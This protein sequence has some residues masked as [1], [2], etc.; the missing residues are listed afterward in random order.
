MK[1][2]LFALSVFAVACGTAEKEEE[3]TA[4]TEPSS[5]PASAPTSSPTSEPEGGEILLY[6]TSQWSGEWTVADDALTG[7]EGL[8]SS[9]FQETTGVRD[10]DYV[11]NLAGTASTD[12]E[13]CVWSFSITATADSDASTLNSE[14][15]AIEDSTFTYAYTTNYEYQGE[16]MGDA[17]LYGDAENDLGAFVWPG[18]PNAPTDATYTSEIN[19]D[20]TAGSFSYTSG[21]IDYE[22]LYQY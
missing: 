15:C 8:L 14:D 9:G 20:E 7:T 4:T 12:C 22:Y 18:N 6:Y 19:W 10:C 2:Y 13:D 21:Y 1:S 5:E 11:W 17:L 3:D 16:V